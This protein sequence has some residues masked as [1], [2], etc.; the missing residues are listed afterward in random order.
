MAIAVNMHLAMLVNDAEFWQEAI[1][2]AGELTQ[3]DPNGLSAWRRRGDALWAAG[4]RA[5]AARAYQRALECDANFE[6][7]VL[8][9]LSDSQRAT[10]RQRIAET[11][12]SLE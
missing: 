9:Q 5:E 6:L 12:R 1:A 3:R 7:D 2:L 11:Q 4:E 8:K 10:L